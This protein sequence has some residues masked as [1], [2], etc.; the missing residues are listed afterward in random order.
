MLSLVTL[1][2]RPKGKLLLP[3]SHQASALTVV[4]HDTLGMCYTLT[5]YSQNISKDTALRKLT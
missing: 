4:S 1:D 2:S 3:H 5:Q